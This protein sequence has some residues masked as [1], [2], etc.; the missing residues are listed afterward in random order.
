VGAALLQQASEADAAGKPLSLAD[1]AT[2]FREKASSKYGGPA[3][4]A[5]YRRYKE[6][7]ASRNT[8]PLPVTRE[9]I[10]GFLVS[11]CLRGN[12]SQTL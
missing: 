7:C 11:W 10:D 12:S 1:L 9:K 4:S 8:D 6:A 5:A 2:R 3:A